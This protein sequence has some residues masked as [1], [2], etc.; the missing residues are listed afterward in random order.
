[1]FHL[2][3]ST[4]KDNKK[5]IFWNEPYVCL[6]TGSIKFLYEKITDKNL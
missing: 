5:V 1:M 3:S 6:E 2:K 4:K